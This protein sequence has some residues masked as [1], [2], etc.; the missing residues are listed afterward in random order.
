MEAPRPPKASD[1]GP[2]TQDQVRAE[3]AKLTD[4]FNA[5]VS[6][7]LA[8]GGAVGYVTDMSRRGGNRTTFNLLLR[9]VGRRSG[10]VSLI[11]LI[12]APWADECVLVASKGGYHAH[13]AW[14]YNLT[15]RRYAE[16]QMRDRR[17]RGPWRLAAEDERARLWEYVTSYFP[18]YA[19]YQTRTDRELPV[20]VLTPRQRI[21]EQWKLPSEPLVPVR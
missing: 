11:P 15:A 21:Q 7:Y 14:Y 2:A 16:W 4:Y 17:F 1:S 12:Y 8:T 6:D 10:R 13:P 19:E 5:H 3:L 9:T 20:V 18:P